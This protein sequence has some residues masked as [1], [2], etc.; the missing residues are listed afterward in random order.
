[1]CVILTVIQSN[2]KFM[3]HVSF[4]LL[5]LLLLPTFGFTQDSL[6]FTQQ[7]VIYGHKHG[8]GLTMIMVKPNKVNGKGIIS[9]ISGDWVSSYKWY[10][11]SLEGAKPFLSAGYTVFLVMHSSA[12][13]FDITAAAA[14]IKRSIQFVRYN[15]SSY[16]IDPDNIGVTGG[17]SGGHLAL[18]AGTSENIS[19]PAAKDP[20]ER[21]SSK[22]Q[23]AAVFFPPTDF[24]NW[25]QAGFN[26]VNQKILL[27]Q[28]G[29]LGAFEFKK[30]DSTKFIYTPIEDKEKIIAIA[31]SISPAQLATADDAP[32]YIIHGDKD[33]TIPFQ[34][35]ELILEKLTA[36]KVPV[37]LTIKSGADHGWKNEN[38][39]RKE[40]VKWFD[41]Y[42][43][44]Q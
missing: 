6:S 28:L 30:F 5:F 3:R 11:R 21:V 16:G 39:D 40:F 19:N 20:V 24:L 25:G 10:P 15:A 36:V 32:T 29:L 37:V 26:P 27:E 41:K 38:E 8:M 2:S 22:V 43:K 13:I 33:R 14:D 9:I 35:S 12:P 7:E 23:A 1:L 17:S 31:K 18:V 4:I 42:L 44:V 34:Q